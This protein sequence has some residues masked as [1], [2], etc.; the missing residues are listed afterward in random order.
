MH[1]VDEREEALMK[2]FEEELAALQASS[3]RGMS[4]EQAY[5]YRLQQDAN[6]AC[7]L[8]AN[9]EIIARI[10][11]CNADEEGEGWSF[12]AAESGVSVR[13]FTYYETVKVL[14]RLQY[15]VSQM[16]DAELEVFVKLYFPL[17]KTS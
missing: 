11:L 7:E 13:E 8:A 17:G 15:R 10:A 1:A 6:R 16:S 4:P 12:M 3:L 9:D 5:T 14:E 2:T